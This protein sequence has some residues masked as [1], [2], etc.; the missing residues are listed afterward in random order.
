M[1]L[2]EKYEISCVARSVFP[3][4]GAALDTP[5]LALQVKCTVPMV[6]EGLFYVTEATSLLVSGGL[7]PPC[8][9]T[10]LRQGYSLLPGNPSTSLGS[11]S[12][13]SLHAHDNVG[14]RVEQVHYRWE[15]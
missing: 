14:E 13:T 3:S 2:P 8:L 1:W 12:T 10:L 4:G 11:A 5:V 6:R 7:P 15:P 9:G